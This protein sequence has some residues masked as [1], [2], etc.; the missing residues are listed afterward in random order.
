VGEH[1]R[2]VLGGLLGYAAERIDALERAGVIG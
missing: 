2:V 1:T